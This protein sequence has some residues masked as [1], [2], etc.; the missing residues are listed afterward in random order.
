MIAVNL[1]TVAQRFFVVIAAHGLTRI[2]GLLDTGFQA[3]H[4]CL[5][6]NDEFD[7]SINLLAFVFEHGVQRLCL[8]H[9]TGETIENY[10]LRTVRLF[11]P[12]GDHVH[13]NVIGHEVAGIHN[14]L[15]LFAQIGARR[16]FRAQHIPRGQL[17]EAVFGLKNLGLRPLTR[18][19]RTD[20]NQVHGSASPYAARAFEFRLFDQTF[21]LMRDQ[22]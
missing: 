2:D 20:Q 4:Q 13:H 8:I 6:I 15:C 9:R 19:R 3:I 22:V 7:D 10:T 12:V 17:F 18:P 21:I 11:D 14:R 5:F 16:D 1:Q